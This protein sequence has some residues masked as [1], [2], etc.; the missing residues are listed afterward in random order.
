MSCFEL[1]ISGLGNIS[2]L[3]GAHEAASRIAML[4]CI[5][6]VPINIKPTTQ[7]TPTPPRRPTTAVAVTRLRFGAAYQAVVITGG[8]L[9]ENAPRSPKAAET[10]A[11]S[12][13]RA[14][15]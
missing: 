9:P 14:A 13:K 6:R 2:S 12:M 11:T 4:L 5:Q 8:G 1:F 7:V 10:D 15:R 3:L